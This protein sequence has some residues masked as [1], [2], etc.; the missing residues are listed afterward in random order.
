[1][2]LQDKHNEYDAIYPQHV[3]KPALVGLAGPW[4]SGG[5][6]FNW[7]VSGRVGSGCW[8]S[9]MSGTPAAS[10]VAPVRLGSLCCASLLGARRFAH[11]G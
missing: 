9:R 5:V 4:I 8:A 7:K 1:M 6:E 3:I 2:P 10:Y 11:G